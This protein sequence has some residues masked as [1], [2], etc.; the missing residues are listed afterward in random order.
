MGAPWFKFYPVDY[1]ADSKV[2]RLNR[3]HRSMLLDCWCWIAQDGSIP[4]DPKELSLLLGDDPRSCRSFL[5]IASSFFVEQ[6]GR[7]YSTR[8]SVE[9]ENY[10][11]KLDRLRNNASIGGKATQANAKAKAQ[12]IAKP[13]AQAKSTESESEPEKEVHP[14]DVATA[15]AAPS[16]KAPQRKEPKPG[17][18]VSEILAEHDPSSYWALTKHFPGSRN[19]N[20]RTA[21]VYWVAAL[22]SGIPGPVIVQSG[23]QFMESLPPDQIAKG[24]IPQLAKWLSEEGFR[25]FLPPDDPKIPRQVSESERKARLADADAFLNAKCLNPSLTYEKWK[26]SHAA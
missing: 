15:P 10:K 23:K 22:V 13:N 16:R 4:N 7:L 9:S 24:A 12:A 19:S 6:N 14:T 25:S 21:A 2:K 26:A 17:P 1:L 20:H 11:A 18:T 8:L 5:Q 3:V